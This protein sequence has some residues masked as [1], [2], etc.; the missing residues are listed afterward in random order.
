M[1]DAEN[2]TKLFRVPG[3]NPFAGSVETTAL[4]G[5][6]FNAEQGGL[7]ALVG[8]NGAGK[9]TLLR[10]LSTLIVPDSGKVNVCG[11]DAM[12]KP[13]EVRRRTGLVT[14]DERSF[15]W[16]LSGRDNLV[17][18]GTLYDTPR[19]KLNKRID[20]LTELFGLG[21]SINMPVRTYSSGMKQ[22]LSLARCLIHD[23]EILLLDEPA[24]GLDPILH[25]KQLQLIRDIIV[26]EFKRTVVV[27]THN[28]DDAISLGGNVVLIDSGRQIYSGKPERAEELLAIL[29]NTSPEKEDISGF[30]LL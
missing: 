20:R 25:I 24:R 28:L 27:A 16:R 21:E 22:R 10:I 19:S 13:V 17:L 29:K 14:G 4:D 3:L 26:K 8:R 9:S 23:P 15:Y 30:N 11:F 2:I 7:T 12:R 18:F 5:F 6:S 1:I